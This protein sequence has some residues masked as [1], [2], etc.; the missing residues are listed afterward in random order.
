MIEELNEHL[1]EITLKA[2]SWANSLRCLGPLL[3]ITQFPEPKS[4][5]VHELEQVLKCLN[6]NPG[7]THMPLLHRVPPS[8]MQEAE[9]SCNTSKKTIAHLMTSDIRLSSSCYPAQL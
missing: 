3:Q 7:I 4:V 8:L 1:S 5:S 9:L 6:Q 2:A